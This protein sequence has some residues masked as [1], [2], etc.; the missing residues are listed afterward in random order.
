MS[1]WNPAS[2]GK[3][4]ASEIARRSTTADHGYVADVVGQGISGAQ[5]R[6]APQ[7]GMTNL[8]QAATGQAAQIDTNPQ[9]QFRG[10]QMQQA[11]SLLAQAL[12][13]EKGAGELAVERQAQNAIAAQRAGARS[14]RGAMGGMA[15]LQAARNASMISGDAIGQAQQASMQDKANANALLNQALQGGRGQDIGLATSQAGFGQQMNLAN[16]QALNDRSALQGQLNQGTSLANLQA[17]LQ[18]TGMNDAAINNYLS[19]LLG[20]NIAEMQTGAGMAQQPGYLGGLLNTGGQVL[21][22][23]LQNS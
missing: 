19:Q 12:G 9:N 1:W 20:M 22:S 3:P 5:G 18:Q 21:G 2:W 14:A 7:A 11:N 4:S 17:Q 23:Y 8:G 10:M 15:G 16:M 13:N 6:P